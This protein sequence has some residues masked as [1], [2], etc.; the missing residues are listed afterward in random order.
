MARTLFGML[1]RRYGP[2]LSG[3]ERDARAH[4]KQVEFA[5][6]LGLASLPTDCARALPNGVAIVGGGFAGMAAAWTLGQAGVAS[7][8]FE[9]RKTYGG[10]VESDRSFI[11]GR[12]IEAG[13]ELIGM[14]HPMWLNLAK[15]FGLGMIVLTGEDQYEGMGLELPL[16]IGGNSVPDRE[17]LYKQM[18]FVLQKI[19]D[20]AKA[21]TN[22]FEPWTTR[23]ATALDALSVADRIAKFVALL[24]KSTRHPMLLEALE[25]QFGNDNVLPTKEQSYL[26][27]LALVSGGRL[28]KDDVDLA[29]YWEH[30][31]DFRCAE[32]NDALAGMMLEYGKRILFRPSS[33]VAKIEISEM[34]PLVK[35]TWFDASRGYM[36]KNFDYIILTAPPSVWKKI[37]ITPAIPP[38][39]EMGLGPAVKY[40][41]Q[42]H[43][44]FWIK[45]GMAP[46]GLSDTLGQTWEATENQALAA[47]GVV[48]SVFA[49]GAFVPSS[50]AAK[51]FR[52]ELLKLYPGYR[53]KAD[54]YADWPNVP[55]IETGYA[56]PKVGQVTTVAK[57]LS[58]PHKKR[59]L[60]AGEHTSMAYFGH[61]EGALQS[62]A[63]AAK[64]ILASCSTKPASSSSKTPTLALGR[65]ESALSSDFGE[66]VLKAAEACARPDG[67]APNSSAALLASIFSGAAGADA[68]SE[69]EAAD[70]SMLSP[71]GFGGHRPTATTLFNAFVY[72]DHPLRPRRALHRHYALR[73]EVLA[74]AGAPLP[75]LVPR[76][77]D[78]L[79]RVACGEGWGH[80]AVVASP[81][82]YWHDRLADAGLRGEGYPLPLPGRHVHVVEAGPRPR[83][84]DD[85]F[86]R[87]LCDANGFV[88]A[89]T[90][91]L[92]PLRPDRLSIEAEAAPGLDGATAGSDP[93]T[94]A[95]R[96]PALRRGA[97]GAAVREAQQKLNRVHADS[98]AL[99]LPGLAGCPLSEDGRFDQRTEQAVSDF[100]QQV[101]GDPAKWN[102]VIG[103]DTWVQLDLLTGTG[104]PPTAGTSL[105]PTG[106]APAGLRTRHDAQYSL[107]PHFTLAGNAP[108]SNPAGQT[109]S[110]TPVPPLPTL[111][112]GIDI[113][114]KNTGFPKFS[115]IAKAGFSFVFHKTSQYSVDTRFASRW[116]QIA[117]A[118]ML[119]GAY[120][121]FSHDAGSVAEQAERF[122][123]TVGR[124]V[125]GDLGPSLDLE[126]RDGAHHA[127]F[128]A[129]RIQ[130]FADLIEA[131]L[132]R[133]PIFYTSRSYW[134]EFVNDDLRFGQYPLWVVWVN[135]GEPFLPAGWTKWQ[136]WQ[137]H[138][139]KSASPMPP[140]FGPSD[141]GV[142]LDRFNG[143]IYQLRGMADLG[144]TAPHLLGNQEFLGYTALDG[145]IHLLEYVAGS[146]RDENV[147]SAPFVHIIGTFPVAAGDPAAVA[148]GN[149]QVIV[150]RS[151]ND[152]V[153]ALTRTLTDPEPNWHAV[154][155]TAGGRAIGDP[156][157]LL[158]ERNVHVIYWDQFNAQVHVMRV[159]GV[160][161]AESFVD[162][163]SP[164][165]P[166]QISGS[167]T[168]YEHRNVLHIVSRS[169]TDGH[170]MDFS[171][172]AGG[173][174]PQD[175]TTA[176]HGAGG[177]RPPAATYRPAT[178]TP[179]GKAARIVFRAV[180]GDI[181]Q[182]ERDT[183]NAT[184]LRTTAVDASNARAVAPTAVGSPT[185][186]FVDVP[187]VFYRTVAGTVI[188]LFGDTN[189]L[190][191]RE[192]CIDAAADPTAFVD[193]LGHAAVSFRAIDGTIRVARLVNGA[194]KWESTTRPRSGRSGSMEAALTQEPW[195]V[196]PPTPALH[197]E[198]VKI[199]GLPEII[200]TLGSNGRYQG[201]IG[202][203]IHERWEPTSTAQIEL[204]GRIQIEFSGTR[205]NY[206]N[207]YDGSQWPLAGVVGSA[208]VKIVS[209]D[210]PSNSVVPDT[211]VRPDGTFVF[212]AHLTV[213]GFTRSLTIYPKVEFK[214]GKSTAATVAVELIDLDGFLA[215]VDQKE[216]ARPPKQTHLE[217]LAS[218]R[219]IYQGGPNDPLKGAF[220]W[221]LYRH[222]NVKPL[223][224]PDSAEDKRFKL[225]KD[226]LYADG[227]W[228]D[229]GH[230]L[231]G[232]EGS[233]KQAPFKDQNIPLPLR[234]ELLVTWAGDLGNA[235]QAYIKDFWKAVDKG[236]PLELMDYLLRRA[237]RIDLIG[238]IDGIN[239]GSTYDSSRSLAEN[240]RAYYGQKSR[241]RYH[242][243][244]ANSK[245][246][247]GKA[248]LPLVPGK[249]PAQ[250]T[251]Q[252]RQAIADNTRQFLVPFWVT[253]KLYS[254]IDPSKRKLV[255]EIMK[256]DS[257][258]MDT[259]V[260]YFARFIEDGLA[261][262]P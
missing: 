247:K 249:K 63:R 106:P 145:R 200:L 192:V 197:L 228:L 109:A 98:V 178:Y 112:D 4:S 120:H 100:Q 253:D 130:E 37:T 33:P 25:L 110:G 85:R 22:P 72:P 214:G 236:D 90:L 20:D 138:Y 245:D 79:L 169:R 177:A 82:L 219:K 41:S 167:A 99:G 61:M 128:W 171:A 7:T 229:I 111:L 101:F 206:E 158:F 193:S 70:E 40:L 137:W 13:A 207:K 157:V 238:D 60:F 46:S 69:A 104:S 199:S 123:A 27:L 151:A 159:N 121:L 96:P 16:L 38:G 256:V 254:G 185:A 24:P 230:V 248:E 44:R 172:P 12:I 115:E 161:H 58:V 97:S 113:Y 67:A 153:H 260:E 187:H 142:D 28:S 31:E 48:L 246:E 175:L 234:A 75:D 160:W 181:W 227:E 23:G 136:F 184:N 135:P 65:T 30:N 244:I 183:L 39:R 93:D 252:A 152:G 76:P 224:F 86:A 258:E 91:L 68:E 94:P 176:S 52:A 233:S 204:I 239:I 10:R 198:K 196:V 243:F 55:W 59:L 250:I 208:P 186:N 149:E 126:D 259:V 50:D 202:K 232:I 210:G 146:W 261:R 217:F 163:V 139:E 225:Y 73:F 201:F 203:P 262:E 216:K 105:L 212:T 1:H 150:Y 215:L 213:D 29:G 144:H 205:R 156:F 166:S 257:P 71:L 11:P 18:A 148:F 132:G 147:F 211:K 226:W 54:R 107:R 89:D 36:S 122:G 17:K 129:P 251:K 15:R 62:G 235:L 51:H 19:S 191:W 3:A 53:M 45:A 114:Q 242:E 125:P 87:R 143:T 78:L 95:Q 189:N 118:G 140:P 255:D 80:I 5:R 133:Q 173:A 88:L 64:A 32:G 240:L 221:V 141:R 47:Q 168:A 218:V 35:V 116:P 209:A 131:R 124:L 237:S 170:L 134:R 92:R 6:W 195:E 26:G 174:P 127:D 223:V 57:F 165:T 188:D 14:N 102:G 241:H 155:I 231:T 8:V 222:R 49:G 182:I 66:R 43:D 42:V 81:G 84:A 56:C 117:Q 164:N 2:T 162:R 180:R 220:D 83:S 34:E 179:A 77:G 190:R 119:R 103:A 194:W 74:P 9:A 108:V 154:D 21:V